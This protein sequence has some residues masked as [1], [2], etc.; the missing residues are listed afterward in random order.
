VIA[1][2]VVTYV[3]IEMAVTMSILASKRYSLMWCVLA[4]S[5][6]LP[7]LVIAVIAPEKGKKS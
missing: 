3:L 6:G 2:L 1:A 7:G 4:A 5:L